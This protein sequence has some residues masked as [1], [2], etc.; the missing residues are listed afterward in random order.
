MKLI[1]YIFTFFCFL[2]V[3]TGCTAEITKN[4][5]DKQTIHQ[6]LFPANGSIPLI[7]IMVN[8]TDSEFSLQE[9]AV[10]H[11]YYSSDFT[12]NVQDYLYQVSNGKFSISFQGVYGPVDL[13]SKE[14]ESISEKIALALKRINGKDFNLRDYDR[15]N[16]EIITSNELLV[17][18]I[19]NGSLYAAATRWVSSKIRDEYG[20]IHLRMSGSIHGSHANLATITHEIIH[21]LGGI[22]IYGASCNSFRLTLMSC[23]IVGQSGNHTN[24]LDPFHKIQ[25]D[26]IDPRVLNVGE[27]SFI[28]KCYNI[29]ASIY[30]GVEPSEIQQPVLVYDLEHKT[31][32]ENEYF[33]LEF[34]NK[35]AQPVDEY[36]YDQFLP[37]PGYG[38]VIWSIRVDDNG[39]PFQVPSISKEDGRDMTIWTYGSQKKMQRLIFQHT[40]VMSLE[41][42]C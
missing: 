41:Q 32:N 10:Y 26:W 35:H 22:D 13:S 2:I 9:R 29:E 12:Y 30:R 19:S 39:K 42:I 37:S 14:A 15:N 1:I 33:L 25:L 27:S 20:N 31:R 36:L 34:R 11:D 38:V 4:D 28:R 21:L 16:D 17:S 5:A 8:N 40:Q 23:T 24:H 7:A 6:D 3:L 18:V